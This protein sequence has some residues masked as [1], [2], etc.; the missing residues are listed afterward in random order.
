VGYSGCFL[1]LVSV[2]Y[3]RE[4]LPFRESFTNVVAIV[5]QYV[6]LLVFLA[7]SMIET[8]TLSSAHLTDSIL[9][10]SL[11]AANMVL[12]SLVGFGGLIRYR[13]FQLNPVNINKDTM[14]IEWA[15]TF[16]DAKV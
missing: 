16:T 5:A 3:F 15:V 7:A 11:V 8:N 2:I 13:Y 9:G 14:N 1:A 4:L 6:I 10:Y 12:I